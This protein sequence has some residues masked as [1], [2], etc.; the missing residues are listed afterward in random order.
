MQVHDETHIVYKI[1]NCNINNF[2]FPHFFI[3][4][5]FSDIFYE[6]LINNLP[7]QKYLY[8]V[9][10]KR[11][12]DKRYDARYI[13]SL[14][15]EDLNKLPNKDFWISVRNVFLGN[16]LKNFILNRFDHVLK[17]IRPDLDKYKTYSEL[18]IMNDTTGFDLQPH[19]DSPRKILSMLFYLPKSNIEKKYGTS[20]YLPKKTGFEDRGIQ[21]LDRNDFNLL[22][23]FPYVKNSVF[24]FLKTNNSFHGVEKIQDTNERWLFA[25]DI[26]IKT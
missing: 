25:Y 5:I 15:D 24:G 13:L 22:Y 20:I 17:N 21:H 9:S 7:E 19:T 14:K 12:V 26:S 10:E 6:K 11:N 4:D 23:T 18:L 2:P 3:N 16:N 1:G 8:K